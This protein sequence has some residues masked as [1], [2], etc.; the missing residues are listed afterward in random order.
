MTTI[1]R[2]IGATPLRTTTETWTVI[3]DLLSPAGADI[4]PQLAL[5][6]DAA[7]MLIA[8]EH[9][10]DDPI[11][12]T[13]CGA[14]VRIYTL[15]GTNAINGSN[16]NEQPLTITATPDWELALPARGVD[17]DLAAAAVESVANITVYDPTVADSRQANAIEPTAR[18]PVTIDLTA[19]EN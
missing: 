19:L 6:A 4:A 8:E 7:C 9:S 12:V 5:A 3:T 1:A 2:R 16:T 14:Q 18:Q 17:F 13:G 11:L 15:H 10:A